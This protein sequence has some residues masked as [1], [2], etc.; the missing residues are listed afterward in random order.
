MSA[1]LR[2]FAEG[3]R[4]LAGSGKQFVSEM[5]TVAKAQD[6]QARLEYLDQV[7]KLEA[8]RVRFAESGTPL[9][10][11]MK[12]SPLAARM[13][14]ESAGVDPEASNGYEAWLA[15]KKVKLPDVND[16]NAHVSQAQ[17]DQAPIAGEL[18]GKIL[19]STTTAPT[20]GPSIPDVDTGSPWGNSLR[21]YAKGMTMKPDVA[22]R[23]SAASAAARMEAAAGMGMA[24][25]SEL[26]G[27]IYN[28]RAS[29]AAQKGAEN[30]AVAGKK[31]SFVSGQ[32]SQDM[33][34]KAGETEQEYKERLAKMNND[35][36]MDR[37]RSKNATDIAVAGIQA[38]TAERR[39][40]AEEIKNSRENFKAVNARIAAI[41]RGIDT[42][43]DNF[44]KAK[45][46]DAKLKALESGG[47]TREEIEGS[48]LMK[49]I[50]SDKVMPDARTFREDALRALQADSKFYQGQMRGSEDA[51]LPKK[52]DGSQ[53]PPKSQANAN[54][55]KLPGA[56]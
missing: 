13:I 47:M 27:K 18:A 14:L 52:V 12:T 44:S 40:S 1:G 37:Q 50:N 26:A 23:A 42:T 11:V 16:V 9:D 38:K 7:G 41:E 17:Y 2:A 55:F 30:A 48:G 51:S 8:Q 46:P 34:K 32:Y 33:A 22:E 39:Y 53:T 15:R 45:G 29:Q 28:V 56:K 10:E 6:R 4:G 24:D 36:E 25:Q 43:F 5:D 3:L 31:E 21:D 54:R 20:G 19:S 35:A 49:W